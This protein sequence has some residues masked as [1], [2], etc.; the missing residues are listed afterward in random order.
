MQGRAVRE[1]ATSLFLRAVCAAKG[2]YLLNVEGRIQ[3]ATSSIA[4][5]S[6]GTEMI[7]SDIKSTPQKSHA[8]DFRVSL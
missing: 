4:D 5:P 1:C 8:F 6:K 3:V 2:T 7:L